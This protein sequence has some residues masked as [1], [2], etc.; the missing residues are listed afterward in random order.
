MK[1]LLVKE[2]K[3]FLKQRSNTLQKSKKSG[4]I[5]QRIKSNEQFYRKCKITWVVIKKI[6]ELFKV[7]LFI[8][9]KIPFS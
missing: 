2:V 1:L 5:F 8:L 4:N 9:S 6:F 3:K 7:I